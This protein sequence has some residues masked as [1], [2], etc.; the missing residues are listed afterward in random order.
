MIYLSCHIKCCFVPQ[1]SD[2]VYCVQIQ[3]RV[4]FFH[5]PKSLK[6]IPGTSQYHSI[7]SHTLETNYQEIPSYVSTVFVI[8]VFWGNNVMMQHLLVITHSLHFHGLDLWM[9]EVTVIIQILEN[10]VPQFNE[11]YISH[12]PTHSF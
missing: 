12:S 6:H 8:V 11:I 4:Y 2:R 9:F 7:A 1:E 5:D 10:V 3:D